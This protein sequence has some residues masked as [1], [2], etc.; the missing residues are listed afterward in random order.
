M[1][2]LGRM[3][4]DTKTQRR[5]RQRTFGND[6]HY[7][8]A[9]C[10]AMRHPLCPISLFGMRACIHS[11]T[12]CF[13]KRLRTVHAAWLFFSNHGFDR[14]MLLCCVMLCYVMSCHVMLCYVIRICLDMFWQVLRALPLNQGFSRMAWLVPPG[15][16]GQIT[17]TLLCVTWPIRCQS[18]CEVEKIGSMSA[19]DRKSTAFI[20]WC[21]LCVFW[22]AFEGELGVLPSVCF[23][24]NRP[25]YDKLLWAIY[26]W[27]QKTLCLEACWQKIPFRFLPVSFIYLFWIVLVPR[28]SL[29]WASG[30]PWASPQTVTWPSSSADGRLS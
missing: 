18:R 10:F 23:D 11:Q 5:T 24:F 30:T 8:H 27:R 25:W 22:G 20:C 17:L 2:F 19:K 16:I 7:R 14:I 12:F 29:R 4:Q 3:P 13:G 26:T 15:A 1:L 21:H 6:G 9:S 28:C